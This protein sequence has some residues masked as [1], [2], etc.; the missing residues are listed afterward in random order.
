MQWLEWA[1][2]L[3]AIAQI[4]LTYS[5]NPYDIERFKS[6]QLIAAEIAATHSNVEHSYI[7]DLFTREVGYAT[8]KV[9]VRGVVFRDNQILL[10]KEREDGCWT[11][12]GGW[13]DV[14][15]SPSEAVVKEIRE[16]SGYLTRAVKLLAVYDR[17]RHGHPPHPNYVYKLFFLCELISGSPSPSIETEEVDFFPEDGIPQ[18]SLGRVTPTQIARLFEHYR[19]PN[20]PTDFD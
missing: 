5:Q 2:K 9:D 14:G 16:E 10:V 13:A 17:N 1:Q 4:G 3:Q 20:L 11:L 18:L 19:N 6:I 12:P 7:L 8:P 15:E